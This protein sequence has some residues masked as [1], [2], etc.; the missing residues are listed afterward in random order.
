VQLE[1][2]VKAVEQFNQSTDALQNDCENKGRGKTPT[3]SKKPLSALEEMQKEVRRHFNQILTE[4]SASTYSI[5]FI[6]FFLLLLLFHMSTGTNCA[7]TSFFYLNSLIGH[8]LMILLTTFL[9]SQ[10]LNLLRNSSSYFLP[11]TSFNE[12]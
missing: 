9:I 5:L 4:A 11:S 2:Q 12:L 1:K 6:Y 3:R 7:H 8:K 10:N